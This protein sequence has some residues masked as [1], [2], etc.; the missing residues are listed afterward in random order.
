MARKCH[1]GERLS[2]KK[3]DQAL[4]SVEYEAESS[5]ETE[6]HVGGSESQ[7]VGGSALEAA[8]LV[9]QSQEAISSREC[10][11]G[12]GKV[13]VR[14]ATPS[15]QRANQRQKGSAVEA[16]ERAE[17]AS[18]LTELEDDHPAP[19]SDHPGQ[20]PQTGKRIVDVAD[21]EGDRRNVEPTVRV[22][23]RSCIRHLE[24]HFQCSALRLGGGYRQ[25]VRTKVRANHGSRGTHLAF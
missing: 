11:R 17:P 1:G 18:R 21:S 5:H 15:E 20:L 10:R 8:G 22:G 19:A 6:I 24:A 23:Q 14:L 4:D 25:H 2:T 12:P 7:G 3:V 16:K 13:L 9:H